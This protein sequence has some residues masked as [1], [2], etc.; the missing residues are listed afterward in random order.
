L[1]LVFAGALLW[2]HQE[3]VRF[4]RSLAVLGASTRACPHFPLVPETTPN[5]RGKVR[6]E[7]KD[8]G[9][10]DDCNDYRW[11]SDLSVSELVSDVS[12]SLDGL[13]VRKADYGTTWVLMEKNTSKVISLGKTFKE[14]G[15]RDGAT[16][17]VLIGAWDPCV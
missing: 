10:G 1:P 7:W 13:K 16:L 8:E 6:V 17:V 12:S 3:G 2:V 14:A 4:A 11:G 5:C 9:G 15:I